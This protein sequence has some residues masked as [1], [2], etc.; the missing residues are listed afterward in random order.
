MF[1]SAESASDFS[2]YSVATLDPS[3]RKRIH[4]YLIRQLGK[5]FDFA[6]RYSDDSAHYCTE[7]VLKALDHANL[8]L[9]SS[10]PR[11]DIMTMPEPAFTPDSVRL[12]PRLVQ[13]PSNRRCAQTGASQKTLTARR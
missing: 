6:F 10:L 9:R 11:V 12:A 1:A 3:A 8:D 4:S 2:A 5:P 7:L 13:L